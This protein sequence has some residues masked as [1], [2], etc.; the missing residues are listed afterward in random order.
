MKQNGP[1]YLYSRSKPLEIKTGI[2]DV[3]FQGAPK[4]MKSTTGH[5]DWIKR[6]IDPLTSNS[7]KFEVP[8]LADLKYTSGLFSLII[9]KEDELM[10]VADIIRSFPIIYGFHRNKLFV[11]DNLEEFQNENGLLEIDNDKLEEFIASGMVYGNRT[12]YKNVFGLQAGEIVTIRN[13][14]ISSERY[15]KYSPTLKPVFYENIIEFTNSFDKVMLSVFSAMIDQN[16]NVHHWVVPLSGGHDSRLIVNYLYRLGV[17]NVICFTYGTPNNEQARISKM[18]ADALDYEWHFVEYNANKWQSL[19]DQ[20]LIDYY[21]R[22]AFNGVSNPCLQDFLAI[23]ELKSKK[24][25][26]DGDIII[27]GHTPIIAS[28]INDT[29]LDIRTKKEAIESIISNYF[30]TSKKQFKENIYN[31]IENIFSNSSQEPSN[32]QSFI[33]WQEHQSKYIANSLKTYEWFGLKSQLPFWAKRLVDFWL[34][35]PI[36]DRRNRKILVESKMQGILADELVEIPYAGVSIITRKSSI[37]SILKKLLPA[38][39]IIILLRITGRKSTLN[40]A[41]N[42][43][44]ALKAKS[45]KELLDPLSDFPDQIKPYYSELLHRFPYQVDPAFLTRLYTIRKVIRKY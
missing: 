20:G 22:Y 30:I 7:L 11:T 6:I 26:D 44:F 10:L 28:G 9:R 40:E 5:A 3:Y 31:S 41:L 45:V 4:L 43:I 32:F 42:Q 36:S 38:S 27:P 18:V 13:N 34:S 12:V 23:F 16:P 21:I 8:K 39:I 29:E 19:H 14:E 37:V 33:F 17:K 15:F 24:I 1:I 35:L 25:I 2:F